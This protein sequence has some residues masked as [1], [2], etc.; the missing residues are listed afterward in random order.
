MNWRLIQES[1][2]KQFSVRQKELRQGKCSYDVIDVQVGKENT[3][4]RIYVYAAL[5]ERR[6][7]HVY[8]AK[9]E[10]SEQINAHGFSPSSQRKQL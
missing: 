7:P 9:G 5:E 10:W 2:K 4:S 1:V 3:Q 8:S 6:K